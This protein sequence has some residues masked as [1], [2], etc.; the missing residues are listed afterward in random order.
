MTSWRTE[1]RI[2]VGGVRLHGDLCLPE[3][4]VGLIVFAHG[5]SDSRLSPRNQIVATELHEYGFATLLA[6][7]LTPEEE[8]VD[9]RTGQMRTDV[10]VLADRVIGLI[11]W[12]RDNP[13]TAA[14][15][16]GLFGAS[17]GVGAALVAAAARPEAV[18]AIV[19][20]GGRPD[21]AGPALLEVRAPT[22]FLVGEK[23]IEVL[24]LNEQARNT[25]RISAE[26]RVIAGASHLFSEP[27]ALDQVAEEAA[28]FFQ[29]HLAAEIHHLLN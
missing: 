26:M 8:L 12:A 11:D 27:G 5:S 4:P 16:L 22:M 17:T 23:D 24:D 1:E 20:R 9:A 21:L 7:L 2:E 13:P 19:S 14:L 25:M 28:G 10:G 3:H 29:S 18:R 6:D 15:T